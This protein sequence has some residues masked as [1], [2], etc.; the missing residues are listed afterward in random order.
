[1]EL[2]FTKPNLRSTLCVLF[3]FFY[4]G[5]A[6]TQDITNTKFGKGFL[7]IIAKDSSFSLKLA[8]RIQML[9]S[10]QWDYEGNKYNSPNTNTLIR[11]ARIKLSGFAYS[12][13]LKYKLELG[14][15][16]RDIAGASPFTHNAPRY[17]L[18]AVIKWNFYQNWVLWAGQTKLPGNIERV[19]SS[20]NLQ[21]VDRSLLNKHFNIDRDIG[22][23]IRHHFTF[24]NSF[25]VR[26]IFAV[27]QGE[28]RNITTGNLGGYQYTARVEFL[29][30][31][32]FA[33]N[34]EYSGA[35]LKREKSPKLFLALSYDLNQNAVKTR[36]NQGSYMLNDD[37]FFKTDIHTLFADFIFK[38]NGLSIM[39]EYAQRMANTP[40]ALNT[41]GS[42]TG[43]IVQIGNG[44]NLQSGYLFKN[45]WEIALRFTSIQLDKKLI[46]NAHT[47][48]YTFGISKYILQH[49]L[50]VQSDFS[51]FTSNDK[52]DKLIF[53][54]QFDL[55]F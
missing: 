17:I 51:Y 28:G 25:L 27:S 30:F 29:P 4:A 3:L 50:K 26:E 49:K 37:N 53:R 40:I 9:S 24:L 6:N 35:D 36:S 14:L 46:D 48:Q 15:S 45:N 5:T 19:I 10:S 41:D 38:L 43:D 7:N 44:L 1:M 20:A 31:G 42:P 52:Q 16:N 11:R 55:H 13:K 33:A 32:K 39:A 34:G 23:Q 47:R 12:P 2:F 21:L 18:D 8:T 22:L 54:L